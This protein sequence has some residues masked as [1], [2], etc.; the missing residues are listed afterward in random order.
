[1]GNLCLWS[2]DNLY[3]FLFIFIIRLLCYIDNVQIVKHFVTLSVKWLYKYILL[4]YFI[5]FVMLLTNTLIKMQ[6]NAIG[7][8]L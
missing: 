2:I 5:S 3:L 7:T 4:T 8:Q 6:Q 1:M